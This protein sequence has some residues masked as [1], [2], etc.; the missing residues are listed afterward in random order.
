[1]PDT[2]RSSGLKNAARA[3]YGAF[4]FKKPLFDVIRKFYRPPARLL[5][6]LWF[7]GAFPVDVAGRR[8]LVNNE[9]GLDMETA[10]FWT[11]ITGSWEPTSMSLWIELC[12]RSQVVIDVGAN[13]GVF[14][15]VAKGV[16]PTSRVVAVEPIERIHAKLVANN[17]LNGYDIECLLLALTN[18]DGEGVMYDLPY[19]HVYAVMLNENLHTS[20]AVERKVSVLRGDTLIRE[21][22]LGRV[23]LIKIDVESHEPEVLEGL[24]DCLRTMQP[25]L[26]VEI[27]NDEIGKRVQAILDGHGYLYYAL[28]ETRGPRRVSEIR[29]PLPGYMNHLVC[30]AETAA[31]LGLV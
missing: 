28:D 21:R 15:L 26:L 22:G 3:L 23:D 24:A 16:N 17:D 10:I 20:P 25:A 30:T 7:K 11:G 31:A 1:M 6:H 18:Y 13:T 4:P 27:W 9:R 19:D 12:K 8:F 2:I 5:Y 29:H 14:A